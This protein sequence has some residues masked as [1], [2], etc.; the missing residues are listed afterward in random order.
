MY[1]TPSLVMHSRKKALISGSYSPKQDSENDDVCYP[2]MV[3]IS[4]VQANRLTF[5]IFL[6]RF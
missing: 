6:N 4:K 5:V 3:K 2:A 1:G